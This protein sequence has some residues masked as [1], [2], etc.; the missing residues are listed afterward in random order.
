MEIF[1]E[2]RESLILEIREGI[3]QVRLDRNTYFSLI[4]NDLNTSNRTNRGRRRRGNGEDIGAEI[5][6]DEL[7]MRRKGVM[8]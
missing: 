4:L 6:D 8:R 5:E 2:Q 7:S 1:L 3:S